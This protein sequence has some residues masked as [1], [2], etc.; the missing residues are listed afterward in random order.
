MFCALGKFTSIVGVALLIS[1]CIYYPKRVEVYDSD[2]N[3]K[4]RKLTLG[5]IASNSV[6]NCSGGN[7]GPCLAAIAAVGPVTA[8]VSGSIVVIG[9]TLYYLEKE[10]PCTPSKS[11][12]AS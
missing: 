11:H 12:D 10:G 8:V 2:C 6:P 9:N 1:G 5:V 7:A 4:T 3:I